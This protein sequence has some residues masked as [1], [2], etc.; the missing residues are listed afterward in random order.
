MSVDQIIELLKA[1]GQYAWPAL[2]IFAFW[3]LLPSIRAFLSREN[4]KIKIGE[5]EVSTEQAT[6]SLTTLVSDLQQK[7]VQI[8]QDIS[9]KAPIDFTERKL[10]QLPLRRGEK[11]RILWVDDVPSKI[12]IQVQKLMQDG[13]WI[14]VASTTAQ[15]VSMVEFT[16]Y[17][18]VI[19]DMGRT[20]HGVH[21]PDAGLILAREIRQRDTTIPII[22]FT[23]YQNVSRFQEG[24]GKVGILKI[25]NSTIDLYRAVDALFG[26][27]HNAN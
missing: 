5:M 26:K 12:A 2:A 4:V 20:E 17:D 24:A 19:T 6:Q 13:F 21:K 25:T 3:K 7:V 9:E 1:L 10:A 18:L 27:N 23:T 22:V 16:K 14:D 15:A 8:E 11:P